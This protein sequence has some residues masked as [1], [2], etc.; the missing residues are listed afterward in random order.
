MRRRNRSSD[1][2]DLKE[3]QGIFKTGVVDVRLE[4]APLHKR[5]KR[6]DLIVAGL[7]DGVDIEVVFP[8]RRERATGPLMAEMAHRAAR[9]AVL[10][11]ALLP[12]SARGIWRTRLIDP[13]DFRRARIYQFLAAE[14]QL[15]DSG[16]T[17]GEPPKV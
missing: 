2:C 3:D 17:Y 14:W 13:T 5:S 11:H 10:T 7:I 15:E 16:Q 12:I 9:T 6:G 4:L 1:T 8:G